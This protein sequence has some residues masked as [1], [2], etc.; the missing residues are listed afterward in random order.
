VVLIYL[1][2]TD[3]RRIGFGSMSVVLAVVSSISSV[4]VIFLFDA[5]SLADG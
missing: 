4:V 5:S 2:G 1:R 3:D